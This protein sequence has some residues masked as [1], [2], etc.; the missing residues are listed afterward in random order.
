[1]KPTF[2]YR[3]K[4]AILGIGVG[5]DKLS[6][7]KDIAKDFAYEHIN[8]EPKRMIDIHHYSMEYCLAHSGE[9]VNERYRHNRQGEID[10]KIAEMVAEHTTDTNLVLYRGV[11]DYV[12]DLMKKMQKIFVVVIYTKKDFLPQVL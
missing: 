9:A 2:F 12:Y 3:I 1:M 8:E 4:D 11:C 7:D 5:W 10:L 6:P